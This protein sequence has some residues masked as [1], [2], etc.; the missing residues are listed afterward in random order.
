MKLAERGGSQDVTNNRYIWR[1]VTQSY[2]TDLAFDEYRVCVRKVFL[3]LEK[4]DKKLIKS[5]FNFLY[6]YGKSY[7]MDLV[8]DLRKIGKKNSH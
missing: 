1:S 4:K 8:I 5:V 6:G 3:D 7:I 2:A